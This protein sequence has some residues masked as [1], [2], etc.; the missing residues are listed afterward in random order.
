M[1]GYNR[2]AYWDK[3]ARE[4]GSR[5]EVKTI[6]GDDEPYYRYKRALF[7]KL[8]DTIDFRNRSVL[9]I[10]SGPGG[11]L[12]YLTKKNCSKIAGVDISPEMVKLSSK[13]LHGKG[14]EVSL[15]DGIHLPFEKCSYDIVFTSTV[16]QHNTDEEK[17]KPL[18]AEIGRVAGSEVILFERIEKTVKGHDTNQ[19]RPV[20]Y[21]D[22]MMRQQGF[23]LSEKKFLPIQ[24]SFYTCGAIRKVFNSSSRGEGEPISKLSFALETLTLP[25]TKLLDRVIPSKR[26]LGMLR[27]RRNG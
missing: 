6:A 14:I 21:Y 17:L 19:G 12:D 22:S 27:F 20:G 2:E 1:T 23:T 11:N 15:I 3:V 8:F 4:I 13:L 5:E 18:I 10:G 25:F 24:A 16:L 9:E 26:D 7:L